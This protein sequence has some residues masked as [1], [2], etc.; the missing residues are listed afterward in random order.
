MK[1]KMICKY[2]KKP[3]RKTGYESWGYNLKDYYHFKCEKQKESK[4]FQ[5]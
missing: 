5:K 3:I 4:S 1:E 2:C